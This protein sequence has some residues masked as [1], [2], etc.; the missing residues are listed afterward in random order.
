MWVITP[1]WHA[2]CYP[3][4]GLVYIACGSELLYQR[5]AISISANWET[6]Q[7]PGGK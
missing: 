1:K 6:Y 5:Y 7:E 4:T 3:V 2:K